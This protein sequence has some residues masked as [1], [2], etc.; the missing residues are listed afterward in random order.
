[1][2]CFR[3]Y[4]AAAVGSVTDDLHMSDDYTATAATAAGDDQ[5]NGYY[6]LPLTVERI[7][8]VDNRDTFHSSVNHIAQVN[9]TCTHHNHDVF[10]VN[11][12]SRFSG[13]FSSSCCSG[14]T[15]FRDKWHGPDVLVTQSTV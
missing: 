7:F 1:V 10:R 14:R 15:S 3:T 2:R 4:N 11:L 9:S 6:Q 5:D 8:W 13:P 12:V